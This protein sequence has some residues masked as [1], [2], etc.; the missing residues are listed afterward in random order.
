MARNMAQADR[1]SGLETP[2]QI[3]IADLVAKLC[4]RVTLCGNCLACVPK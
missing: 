4:G 1:S 3:A 2:Q